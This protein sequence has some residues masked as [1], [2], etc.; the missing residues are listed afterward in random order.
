MTSRFWFYLLFIIVII[1]LVSYWDFSRQHLAQKAKAAEA[2]ALTETANQL[3]GY[4]ERQTD[5]LKLVGLAKRLNAIEPTLAK[6]V[7]QRAFELAPNNPD[8][9]YL[10]SAYRPELK[11]K[12]LE[13]NPFLDQK[14]DPQAPLGQLQ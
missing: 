6:P 14:V 11:A 7:V 2:A 12:A 3:K 8:A 5:G 4:L 9:V 10:E 13:L 1:G